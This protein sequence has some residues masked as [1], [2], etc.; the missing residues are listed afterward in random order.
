MGLPHGSTERDGEARGPTRF[1][2][3]AA[4]AFRW[5]WQAAPLEFAVVVVV[6]LA[7][8]AALALVLLSARSVAEALTADV[9]PSSVRDIAPALFGLAGGLFLSGMGMV[10]QRE[11]RLVVSERV[12]YHLQGEIIDVT[13]SVDFEAFEDPEFNDL[14]DRAVG[15]GVQN[16]LQLVYDLIALVS[17]LATSIT[18]LVVL[19][20]ILPTVLPVL[21]LVAIP[22][23][24]AARAS[25]RIAFRMAYELTPDDRL[26]ASL[27]SALVSRREAKEVRVF[28]LRRPLRDRWARLFDARV[29]RVRRVA[30]RRLFFNGMASA[31]ASLLVAGLL[32]VIVDAAVDGRVEV[33]DA[34]IG[35]VALQQVAVRIRTIAGSSGSLRES[36]MFLDD[37]EHFRSLRLENMDHERVEPL[38]PFD[39]L[40]VEQVRFR[41]PGTDRDVL[42]DIDLEIGRGQI[43]ALV[44]A[45][46]SGKTTLAHIVAGLYRPTEGSIRWGDVDIGS[47]PR[48]RLWRSIGIVHQDFV[49][50]QLTARENISISDHTR[51]DDLEQIRTAAERASIATTID[52]LPRGFDSMLSR[53]FEGGQDLSGGEWQ[54]IA[55]ARAFFREAPLIILDEPAAALDAMAER[56][57]YEQLVDL[58][59]DRSALLI[60]H[61]FSTVRMAH[62]IYV[63][64]DG[65]IV[66]RGTH[67]DLMALDGHYAAMFNVQAAGFVDS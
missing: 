37:F 11:G 2:S 55:V 30:I 52:K 47:V 49:R 34:A 28:D 16:A 26:R 36:A 59:V 40:R 46:G 50:F 38:P 65:R 33:A 17:S 13:S 60:S 15:R 8:S 32:V 56:R 42:E 18:L 24:L 44:G 4:R 14:R 53:A 1:W 35:V 41:Y 19:T 27:F 6:Q 31:A 58:C 29:D 61:R 3:L 64:Q 10:V 54:R 48:R 20:A 23:V 57:L 25:A 67:A 22:F 9:A 45:S 51:L 5:V 62:Q 66:E 7:G 43:V 39:T 12:L 63:M 21:V